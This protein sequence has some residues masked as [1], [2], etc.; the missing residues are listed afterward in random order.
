MRR[1]GTFCR[2]AGARLLLLLLAAVAACE[3]DGGGDAG[4]G[5]THAAVV[6]GR[7]AFEF[8]A[9]DVGHGAQVRLGAPLTAAAVGVVATLRDGAGRV[10]AS[11]YILSED[12]S[13]SYGLDQPLV[14]GETIVFSTWLG[15]RDAVLF[16]VLRPAG[17][18][19]IEPDSVTAPVWSWHADV[20]ADGNVGELVIR[21]DE[22]A[23]AIFLYVLGYT[24][25]AAVLEDMLALD[26]TR[27]ASLAI[28]WSPGLGWTC[29]SCAGAWPQQV[30]GGSEVA[31][32]VWMGDE[33][34]GSGA[35][36]Y[37]VLLHELGHYVARNYSRDDSPGGEHFLGQP[38]APAFAW[39][40]GWATWFSAA[41]F[42]RW[43]G[44]PTPIYW[45][46][47]QGSS[48]WAD[49]GRGVYADGEPMARP[50]LDAGLAQ[51]LDENYVAAMLWDLWDGADMAEA[52]ADD[53]T[54]L[55]TEAVLRA[56]AAPRFLRYDRGAQGADLVDFVDAAL[57]AA[58]AL[59]DPVTA[60]LVDVLGF[61]YDGEPR[62]P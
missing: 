19:T 26:E 24:T 59:V 10:L 21:E 2:A 37:S 54:A 52:Q 62:C 16:A 39:S 18:G 45:D 44:S 30:E 48:F 50:D 34:G 32:S 4:G 47:Q 58:P 6:R 29:G 53:G 9:P 36:G 35:W 51:D 22:G 56:V 20:P 28:L 57:C 38:I 41:T 55:G 42:S 23:G 3:G 11:D 60:T 7:L 40:E 12:G 49:L 43:V 31:N 27:L 8:R 15:T 5:G 61:P 46:I 13:F 25:L 14:G 17:T 33:E 1:G